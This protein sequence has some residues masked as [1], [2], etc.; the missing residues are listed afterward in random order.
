MV[1][2]VR[3]IV[4]VNFYQLNF[5]RVINLFQCGADMPL[6]ATGLFAGFIF[7]LLFPVWIA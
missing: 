6:L 5:I 4:A 3:Q 7:W 1:F 2:P